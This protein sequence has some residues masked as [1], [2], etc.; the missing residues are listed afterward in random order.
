MVTTIDD[1]EPIAMVGAPPPGSVDDAMV[2]A[3]YE[4]PLI[5]PQ[6]VSK[7]PNQRLAIFISAIVGAV[8]GLVIGIFC[9]SSPQ[10]QERNLLIGFLTTRVM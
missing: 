8:A 10:D 3:P 7:V 4:R 2:D 9:T 5:E 1:G 6:P